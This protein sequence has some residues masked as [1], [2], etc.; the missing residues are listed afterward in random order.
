VVLFAVL[1]VYA[2]LALKNNYWP[3]QLESVIQRT[4]ETVSP[5]SN[6]QIKKH[7]ISRVLN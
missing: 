6:S 7:S 5:P 4:N 2:F 3:F 1:A